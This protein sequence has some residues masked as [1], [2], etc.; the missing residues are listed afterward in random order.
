VAVPAGTVTLAV[1]FMGSVA[2]GFTLVPGVSVHVE[3]AMPS[4][5]DTVTL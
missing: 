1:M 5:Q 2:V 4:L 3:F